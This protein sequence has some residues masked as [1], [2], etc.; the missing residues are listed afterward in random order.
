LSLITDIL[1]P[2][3]IAR[4]ND[5]RAFKGMNH[6]L[7]KDLKDYSELQYCANYPHSFP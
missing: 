3:K 7:W 4:V 5:H 6:R 1:N 2:Y